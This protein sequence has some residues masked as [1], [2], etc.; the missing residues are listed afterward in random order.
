MSLPRR[1]LRSREYN[2]KKRGTE[3]EGKYC[4][5]IAGVMLPYM[6]EYIMLYQ[7]CKKFSNPMPVF[8]LDK[9]E[10]NRTVR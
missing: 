3:E 6:L 2:S 10:I 7:L 5:S 8:L 4:I 1:P 9:V